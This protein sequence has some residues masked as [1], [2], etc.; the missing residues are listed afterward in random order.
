[1]AL[2]CPF[3]LDWRLG[4]TLLLPLPYNLKAKMDGKTYEV[5]NG[6]EEPLRGH[7]GQPPSSPLPPYT[8]T[9]VMH[10]KLWYKRLLDRIMLK[11]IDNKKD[12]QLQIIFD[13]IS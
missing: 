9:K 2:K 11:Q 8:Y 13:K 3:V 1:M 7:L 12:H 10:K 4:I 5:E 6:P